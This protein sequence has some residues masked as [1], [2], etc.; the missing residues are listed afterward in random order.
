MWPIQEREKRQ[1]FILWPNLI[2]YSKLYECVVTVLLLHQ[3]LCSGPGSN[4]KGRS[5][6]YI[7]FPSS[8]NENSYFSTMALFP[9]F[10]SCEST[11]FFDPPGPGCLG[12]HYFHAYRPSVRYKKPIV[13][14]SAKTKQVT[15][16]TRYMGPGGS[17]N[18]P[19]FLL[20]FFLSPI[21]PKAVMRRSLLRKKNPPQLHPFTE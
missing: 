4:K 18:S 9:T 10:F 2:P 11:N 12:G 19:I 20:S 16:K 21:M 6:G 3:P 5:K 14:E 15:T 1:L 13:K 17:L 8:S 7:F